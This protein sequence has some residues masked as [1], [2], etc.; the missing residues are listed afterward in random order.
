MALTAMGNS[1]QEAIQKSNRAAETITFE[2]KYYR[3]DIGL[4]LLS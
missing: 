4:D 3:K 2:K 1:M